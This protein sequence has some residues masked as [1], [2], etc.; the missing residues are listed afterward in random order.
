MECREKS[1]AAS[2]RESTLSD[3]QRELLGSVHDALDVLESSLRALPSSGKSKT[4]D[5]VLQLRHRIIET[6]SDLRSKK[7]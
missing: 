5:L 4:I 3:T 1:G 6:F 7:S 2:E